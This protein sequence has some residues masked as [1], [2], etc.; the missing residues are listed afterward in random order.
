MASSIAFS[1]TAENLEK[2][3]HDI[4]DAS[5]LLLKASF[6]PAKIICSTHMNSIELTDI[7]IL[8]RIH[9]MHAM[10]LWTENTS[11]NVDM[12]ALSIAH[13][14]T[15]S[16]INRNN[17]SAHLFVGRRFVD[18]KMFSNAI[19]HGYDKVADIWPCF[20]DDLKEKRKVALEEKASI[21]ER[22]A[23]GEDSSYIRYAG[24]L[25]AIADKFVRRKMWDSSYKLS[26]HRVENLASGTDHYNLAIDAPDKWLAIR[27]IDDGLK[28]EPYCPVTQELAAIL[29]ARSESG[30]GI[31]TAAAKDHMQRSLELRFTEEKKS[32][33]DEI[34]SKL[35]V[36]DKSNKSM[37]KLKVP[38]KSTSNNNLVSP[39]PLKSIDI[40]QTL[41]SS[42]L[43]PT[44]IEHDEI[45]EPHIEI[46]AI[47]DGSTPY[48]YDPFATVSQEP[49][50][51]FDDHSLQQSHEFVDE[52]RRGEGQI[53]ADNILIATSGIVSDSYKSS[54]LHEVQHPVLVEKLIGNEAPTASDGA[55]SSAG[56]RPHSAIST[57]SLQSSYE[58]RSVR[59]A[60]AIHLTKC[61]SLSHC[62]IFAVIPT[63]VL[64]G[65]SASPFA[66]ASNMLNECIPDKHQWIFDERV[67]LD[68]KSL[69]KITKCAPFIRRIGGSIIIQLPVVNAA[70]RK[71]HDLDGVISVIGKLIPIP[72]K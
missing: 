2:L 10:V 16:L 67:T 56:K 38:E 49:T 17:A 50:H 47:P 68:S 7:D 35:R 44:I 27:H 19:I 46:P 60:A 24:N 40:P 41:D 22:I 59:H 62:S 12:Y 33:Y 54:Y 57:F 43:K 48:Q 53:E 26:R 52:T 65:N 3:R 5:E 15:A 4:D 69:E 29:K 18:V 58:T 23:A 25:F 28:S 34:L 9:L 72:C 71:Y 32:K 39:V 64:S 45:S 11:K 14:L 66:E 63:S 21:L 13:G 36:I 55:K 51:E 20:S 42:A 70:I 8:S 37:E 30:A 6:G 61:L 1:Y 31:F